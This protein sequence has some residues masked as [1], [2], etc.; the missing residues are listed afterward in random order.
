MNITNNFF[1]ATNH[2]L[3]R[4]ISTAGTN[5]VKNLMPARIDLYGIVSA[6]SFAG[7]DPV[8]MEGLNRIR[9]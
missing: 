2:F 8:R 5:S 3:T 1:L 7:G 9:R 4:A 6:E